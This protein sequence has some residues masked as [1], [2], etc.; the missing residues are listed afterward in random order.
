[1]ISIDVR[2]KDA[3]ITALN[4]IQDRGVIIYPT[5]TIYGFGVDATNDEAI[6]RLNIIKGRTGPISVLVPDEDTA[7]SW[8]DISSNEMNLVKSKLTG[9]ST[10]IY[11]IIDGV[12]NNKILG[13]DHTLGVRMPQNNFC[14]QLAKFSANPI[15]TTS[16]N[17]HGST[18]LNEPERIL[19]EFGKEINLFVNGGNLKGNKESSIYKLEHGKLVQ[20]R[21]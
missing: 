21:D 2:N 5:D 14:N 1:M 7:L 20:L 10:I 18:S 4:I 8:A 13:V 15:T 19:A 11:P 3:V 16:V 12:V 17:R 9:Y 6:Q